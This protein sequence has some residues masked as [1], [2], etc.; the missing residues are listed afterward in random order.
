MNMAR[1]KHVS[2]GQTT[3]LRRLMNVND[4]DLR[5]NNVVCALIFLFLIG[6]AIVTRLGA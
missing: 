4:V 3:L 6:D 5:R 2:T 1:G